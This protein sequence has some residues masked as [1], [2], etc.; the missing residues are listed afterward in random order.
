[1]VT[2][3]SPNP[4][5]T[6]SGAPSG[7]IVRYRVEEISS[8]N[9]SFMGVGVGAFLLFEMWSSFIRSDTMDP[10]CFTVITLHTDSSS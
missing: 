6:S 8:V 10:A 5:Q 9:V 7:G 4:T 3:T 2:K 1:M